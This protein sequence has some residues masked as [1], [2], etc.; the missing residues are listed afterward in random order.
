MREA[1]VIQSKGPEKVSE[2]SIS[3]ATFTIKLSSSAL[4]KVVL[5]FPKPSVKAVCAE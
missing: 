1:P 4:N 3:I 5:P 2:I